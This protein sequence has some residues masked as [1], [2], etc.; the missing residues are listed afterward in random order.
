MIYIC[1]TNLEVS[2][3]PL[4]DTLTYSIVNNPSKVTATLLMGVTKP[5]VTR[6]YVNNQYRS[7]RTV[8]AEKITYFEDDDELLKL[9]G[10][11]QPESEPEVVAMPEIEPA[12]TAAVATDTS[13]A[14]VENM[15]AQIDE[16]DSSIKDISTEEPE[17]V[18]DKDAQNEIEEAEVSLVPQIDMHNTSVYETDALKARIATLEDVVEQT[19][20]CLKKAQEDRNEVYDYAMEQLS[21]QAEEYDAKLKEAQTAVNS[22][23]AQ[24]E[25]ALVAE[26]PLSVFEPYA[27]KCRAII[28]AGLTVATP[29]KGI[30]AISSGSPDT[31]STLYQ[32]LA[33]LIMSGHPFTVF[34]FTGDPVFGITLTNLA[35]KVKMIKSAES[36]GSGKLTQADYLSCAIDPQKDLVNYIRGSASLESTFQTNFGASRVAFSGFYHEIALLT[37]DWGKFLTDV[38]GLIG[39]GNAVILLPA[40]Y[41]FVGRFLTSYL[42]T[43]IPC[44]VGAIC[45]PSALHNVQSNCNTIPARRIRILAMNYIKNQTIDTLLSGALNEKYN[46]RMFKANNFCAKPNATSED[47]EVTKAN[48]NK[49]W[50]V[51]FEPLK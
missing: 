32:S 35:V 18:K 25:N 6:A 36:G 44:N 34:D 16:Q 14:E 40:I 37:F 28:K 23:K 46:I 7:V 22:L 13:D 39:N 50:A 10:A 33:M 48:N 15:Q 30:T 45:A 8:K 38:S 21:Q 24:L 31:T 4:S 41:S 29:L 17:P 12:T 1:G 11:P 9:L 27:A 2:D 5:D 19:R 47:F 42:S 51:A 49:I 26:S 3:L 43:A 20:I